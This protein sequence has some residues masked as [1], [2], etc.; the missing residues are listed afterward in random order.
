VRPDDLRVY[1]LLVG[2]SIRAQMHYR[3]AFAVR[4]LADFLVVVADFLPIYFL[5]RRFGAL[6]G[7]SLAE[8]ALLYGMVEVSWAT[9]EGGLFAF[10]GFGPHLVRGELDRWLLRP[11][12]IVLQVAA[13]GF[14]LRKLGRLGQGLLVLVL[15][16]VWLRLDATAAV[17]VLTGVTGGVL[18]FAGVVILGAA[19]QFWTLGETAELQNM[20]TYGGSAALTYPVSI[21]SKWF[22]RVVTYGVPLA[23]VNY[24]PAL[25][26]LGRVESAGWPRFVPWLSPFVC[27]GVLCLAR[28]AFALGLRRYE[29][30]GS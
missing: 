2:A 5:V 4:T 1:R 8:L 15:A 9:V 18:F 6:E 29:S 3:L 10:E 27:L 21:Y 26:A 25:A 22:R 12:G 24:F 19:S 11:R 7:W 14:E 17:W 28:A 13:H 16:G 20:L 30:T 23:F